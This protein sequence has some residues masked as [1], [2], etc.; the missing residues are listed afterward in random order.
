MDRATGSS[1]LHEGVCSAH[2]FP[3]L[4][5]MQTAAAGHS[6]ATC[7]NEAQLHEGSISCAHQPRLLQLCTKT[8]GHN[9]RSLSKPHLVSCPETEDTA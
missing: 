4:P 6:V 5:Q 7:V 3:P 1:A 2:H 8:N 9:L